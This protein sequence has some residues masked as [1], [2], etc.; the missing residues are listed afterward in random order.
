MTYTHIN[1]YVYDCALCPTRCDGKTVAQFDFERDVRF[2]EAIENHVIQHI[3]QQYPHL[4]AT[5]TTCEGYPDIEIAYRHSPQTSIAFVEIKGQARTFMAVARLLP[6]SGLRPSETIALN[7]SDLERY[8]RV[9]EQEQKP[10]YLVWSLLRRPCIVG[11]GNKSHLFFYQDI[12]V[13][14]N[15][16]EKDS[17]NHRRFRRESG[18]GDVVNGVHKGVTVNYH[19]SLQEL[20][21]G[22][23]N[24]SKL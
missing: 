10:L 5:K 13:L 9:N 12:A 7:L 20:C 23:P 15:I 14:Q 8:F 19:F 16:R 4:I 18:K 6:D 24:L 17:A 21:E 1:N 2:S 11:I 22:L 3:N